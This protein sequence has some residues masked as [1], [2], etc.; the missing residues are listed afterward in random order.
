[1]QKNTKIALLAG[2]T[3]F[4][5]GC[6]TA[7]KT[8]KTEEPIKQVVVTEPVV[9]T[10]P[11]ATAKDEKAYALPAYQASA[12]RISDIEHTK[13]EVSFD[14]AKQ[15][16]FGKA[17]ITAKPYFYPNNELVLDAKSMDI[18]SVVLVD[19]MAT[20]LKF[21]YKNDKLVIALNRIYKNDESY[22]LVIDY[23]AKPE[24]R[25][26]G[27][28]AAISS[29]KGL[30]FINP[31]GKEKDKPMQ[32]WTQGETEAASC[33][34]PTI[35]RPNE[36]CTQEIFITIEDKYKT[37]SNGLMVSSTKNT[38]GTRTD[39]WKQ[40]KPHAPYLFMMAIGE[41]SISKDKWRDKEMLYYVEPEYA[42][43]AK[44]IYNNAPEMLEF[45]SKR[46]GVD[47]PWDKMAHVIVREYVSGAMENTSA[48]V[49][50]DFCQKHARELLD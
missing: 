34:F 28:S 35:D 46:L 45:F 10:A 5:M 13:L 6:D 14:W 39:Y 29:D 49:Y 23:V 44:L 7:Q 26:T 24:E 25:A 36:R 17:T 11:K 3:V 15:Y 9:V 12:K 50:G 1:M 18:K 2:L 30:Y 20:P 37:L 47:Y 33:W 31:L 43:D 38:N 4:A 42:A 8:A 16:L 40:D 27:G 22:T 21:E 19:K 32:I 41:F 48:I